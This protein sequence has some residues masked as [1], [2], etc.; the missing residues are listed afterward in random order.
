MLRH[1]SEVVVV[2]ALAFCCVSAVADGDEISSI[3]GTSQVVLRPKATMLRFQL[4]LSERG[5]DMEQVEQSLD[6]KCEALRKALLAARATP[7]SIRADSVRLAGGLRAVG[8]PIQGQV[9][10]GKGKWQYQTPVQKPIQ[11]QFQPPSSPPTANQGPPNQGPP[12]RRE[13]RITLQ[14]EVTAEWPLQAATVARLLVEADGIVRR[15]HKQILPLVPKKE[16]GS[17]RLTANE[18][19]EPFAP[20]EPANNA[21]LPNPGASEPFDADDAPKADV[22]GPTYL[23]VGVISREQLH[24][25]Y[26]RAFKEAKAD[27]AAKAD[28]AGFVLGRLSYFD[29]SRPRPDGETDPFGS[30]VPSTTPIPSDATLPPLGIGRAAGRAGAVETSNY[31]PSSLQYSVSVNVTFRLQPSSDRS[32]ES[33]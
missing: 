23:F 15:V 12:E 1:W 11:Q 26:V 10:W 20:N 27:A 2:C 6:R 24:E 29:V 4:T 14:T 16:A 13:P 33:K 30:I 21:P 28:I 22:Y 7:G 25:A 31:D 9:P 3:S 5:D 18:A 19:A 17:S 32:T 8:V